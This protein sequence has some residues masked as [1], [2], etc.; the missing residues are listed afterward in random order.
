MLRAV[1]RNSIILLTFDLQFSQSDFIF[2]FYCIFLANVWHSIHNRKAQNLS[3]SWITCAAE[4]GSAHYLETE[5]VKNLK[6]FKHSITKGAFTGWIQAQYSLINWNFYN[7]R[8]PSQSQ[9]IFNQ[10]QDWLIISPLFAWF[11]RSCDSKRYCVDFY[12]STVQ[13]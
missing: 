1:C 13:Y 12:K 7:M 3:D 8:P 9:P 4:M 2:R 5:F 10:I 6:H 11:W